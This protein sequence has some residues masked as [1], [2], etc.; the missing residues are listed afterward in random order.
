MNNL[1]RRACSSC[2]GVVRFLPWKATGSIKLLANSSL[3]LIASVDDNYS[4][5]SADDESA[6]AERHPISCGV[7]WE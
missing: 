4:A 5:T 6:P 2:G 3:A 7:D 1:T